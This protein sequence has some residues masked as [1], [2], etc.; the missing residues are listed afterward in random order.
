VFAAALTQTLSTVTGGVAA[1]PDCLPPPFPM[2]AGYD[3]LG[4][5][6]VGGMGT[7]YRAHDRR[8]NRLVALKVIRAD[9]LEAVDPVSRAAWL[10]RFRAEIE[11]AA[12]LEHP[13]IVALY[14]VGEHEGRPYF[15][16]RLVEG[17]SLAQRIAQSPRAATRELVALLVKVVRAVYFAHQHGVLH[18][19]LKPGNVLLDAEGE[20]HLTDFGLAKRLDAVA[21]AEAGEAAGPGDEEAASGIAGTL[22]YMAPEQTAGR[23]R[24]TTAVDVYALGAILY[25]ILTGRPPFRTGPPRDLSEMLRQV[26]AAEPAPPRLLRPDVPRD[27]EAICLKCLRKDPRQR[28]A[29]AEDVARDLERFLEGRPTQARPGPAWERA[30]KWARRQP[31][32]AALVV[33]VLA[34]LLALGVGALWHN[35]RLRAANARLQLANARLDDALADARRRHYAADMN[36]AGQDWKDGHDSLAL[37]RL[38]R[39]RPEAGQENYRGFEWYYLWRLAHHGRRLRGHTGPVFVVAYAPDGRAVATAS[40]DGTVRLWDPTTGEE[41]AT[42]RRHTGMVVAAAFARDGR[43]L[44]TAGEDRTVVLWDLET[45]QAADMHPTPAPLSCV[46]FTRPD[47]LA[48]GGH[49]GRLL[50]LHVEGRRFAPEPLQAVQAHEGAVRCAA[51]SP[52]GRTLATGGQDAALKLWTVKPDGTLASPPRPLEGG[53]TDELWSVAFSP[54]GRWLAS[55]GTDDPAFVWRLATGAKLA[56]PGDKREFLSVAFAPDGQT[57]ATGGRNGVV[58]LWQVKPDGAPEPRGRLEGHTGPVYALAF[59]PDGRTLASGAVDRLARL[60]DVGQEGRALGPRDG[61][62]KLVLAGEGRMKAAA[63][64]PGGRLV[65]VAATRADGTS[66]VRLWDTATGREVPHPPLPDRPVNALAFAADGAGL[67]LGGEGAGAAVRAWDV[68]EDGDGWRVSERWADAAGERVLSVAFSPGGP[69]LAT[70]GADG[71]V[72][73]R[74]AR[75]GELRGTLTGHAG[76][77]AALAFAPQG[78]VLASGGYDRAVRLWDVAQGTRLP[79]LQGPEHG[80]WVTN[81]AFAPDGK[82]LASASD[83]CTI[84]LWDL[85]GRRHVATLEG[86]AGWIGCLAFAPDGR[87]LVSGSDDLTVKLWD[88]TAGLLRLSLRGH[89]AMVRDAAFGP[90]NVLATVGE[91]RF[92]LRWQAATTEEVRDQGGER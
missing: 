28:Y 9:K 34:A 83:D 48:A 88:P 44:A 19:D 17:V 58:R 36:L 11:T 91:D 12:H 42:L 29:S 39:H 47:T 25:E 70:G 76:A 61:F 3:I 67:A 89:A 22:S 23:K 79:A 32:L 35:D 90:D 15:T 40:G 63:F 26:M 14:D 65:A 41:T 84:N 30:G 16:M 87:T 6:G 60:W 80:D 21:A 55:G 37:S 85:P 75:T 27:L 2:I 20:P 68:A 56:L 66:E 1:P 46:A 24:L 50:L 53:H 73:L 10:D 18:R 8:A 78:D 45:R 38:L 59:S 5:C 92:L 82:T 31:A 71:V 49:D 33:V 51:L 74:D 72:R 81:L 64:R 62:S 54:D 43:T 7:V 69:T 77:V 57:L 4:E 86:H 52:D 13:H